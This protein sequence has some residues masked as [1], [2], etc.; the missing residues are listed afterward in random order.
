MALT[1]WIEWWSMAGS[2]TRCAW[3]AGAP[4]LDV[5][6][7]DKEW[8]V[9]SFDDGHLFEMLILEGAQAG[10][11]WSTVLAK[12][13]G[14]RRAFDG[15]DPQKM[16]RY[17]DKKRAALM[18]NSAIIRNRLKIEAATTNAKAYLELLSS[19]TELGD[20]LWQFVEGRPIQNTW[21]TMQEVPVSTPQSK[22]MSRELKRHGFKFVGETICYA[23]MQ[24]V[25]MVNDHTVDC[26]RHRELST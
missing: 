7:H 18:Q 11:S 21:R 23:F 25:G 3:A 24:A 9:P 20:F 2:P 1:A 14:Y 22:A 5:A 16:A 10:L 19:G 17:S 8:G 4:A 26:F 15:F 6:Y 12:R 13:E